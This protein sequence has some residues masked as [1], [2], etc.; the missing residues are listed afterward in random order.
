MP[1]RQTAQIPGCNPAVPHGQRPFIARFPGEVERNN[2]LGL[3]VGSGANGRCLNAMDHGVVRQ[4]D[5]NVEHCVHL[6]EGPVQQTAETH[7]SVDFLTAIPASG[8][9]HPGQGAVKVSHR[10]RLATMFFSF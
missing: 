5:G 10:G 6:R 2:V 8:P 9:G 1:A 7:L 4:L 3:F